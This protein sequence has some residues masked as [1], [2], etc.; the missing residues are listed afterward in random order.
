MVLPACTLPVSSY[1]RSSDENT[2]TRV[3]GVK[4]VSTANDL[5]AR[6]AEDAKLMNE[7][8]DDRLL[9]PYIPTKFDEE[10]WEWD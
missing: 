5:R 1:G 9:D 4:K 7:R 6:L 2:W 3:D 8:G 10:E